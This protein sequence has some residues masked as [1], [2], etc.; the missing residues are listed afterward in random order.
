MIFITESG[1]TITAFESALN[2][3]STETNTAI[4]V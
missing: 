1:N 4:I 3:G 2:V